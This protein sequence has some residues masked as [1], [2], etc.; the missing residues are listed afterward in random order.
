M[1]GRRTVSFSKGTCSRSLR[2][3]RGSNTVS[4]VL[5]SEPS[6]RRNDE[7][8]ELVTCTAAHYEVYIGDAPP[9]DS[10]DVPAVNDGESR[11]SGA[12]STGGTLHTKLVVETLREYLEHAAEL[13]EEAERKLAA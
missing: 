1:R 7:R 3:T 9:A 12:N 5:T 6:R 4:R 2:K 10:S 11:G 13:V 8:T